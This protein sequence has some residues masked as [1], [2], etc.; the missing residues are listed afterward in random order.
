VLPHLPADPTYTSVTTTGA[1][2]SWTKADGIF[3]KYR[4]DLIPAKGD[5]NPFEVLATA[6]DLKTTLS[7]LT[8]GTIYNFTVRVSDGT[9]DGKPRS[10]I[11]YTSKYIRIL[12]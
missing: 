2:L 11:F 9:T 8:P 7:N 10:V 4:L 6:P 12:L 1:V 3:T 5:M